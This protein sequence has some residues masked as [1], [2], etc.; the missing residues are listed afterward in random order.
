MFMLATI[1]YVAAAAPPFIFLNGVPFWE[2]KHVKELTN[3][4]THFET[5][6]VTARKEVST[7][8]GQEKTEIKLVDD[9]V[10]TLGTNTVQNASDVERLQKELEEL[11]NNLNEA[12]TGKTALITT[13]QSGWAVFVK[14]VLDHYRS[15]AGNPDF[16][17]PASQTWMLS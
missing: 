16:D 1:A 5:K 11:R 14:K 4:I 9:E 15:N 6:L 13:I 3:D 12:K 17:Q 2:K 8:K 10:A 7:V